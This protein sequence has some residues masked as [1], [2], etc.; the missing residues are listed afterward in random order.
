[1]KE[2]NMI[3]KIELPYFVLLTFP[4]NYPDV[5]TSKKMFRALVMRIK[6]HWPTAAVFWK[7]EPQE[8]G[9][10]HF[11]CFIWNV[12]LDQLQANIPVWWYQIAGQGD[13]NHLHFHC[14][15]LP[16]SQHCVQEIRSWNGVMFYATKY[17][18]KNCEADWDRPGRFWGI[19]GREFVPWAQKVDVKLTVHQADILIRY[20]R[21]A[22]KL[23]AH[24]FRSLTLF[25]DSSFWFERLGDLLC[26]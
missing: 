1:M 22:M 23:R 2:L 17:F 24:Q 12:N 8:R 7:M 10:A 26:I 6:R 21:R 25:C 14:G 5:P 13:I 4:E 9:A 16:G 3:K 19:I 18:S 11:H 15:L 20:M